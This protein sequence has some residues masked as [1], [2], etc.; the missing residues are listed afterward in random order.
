MQCG[1]WFIWKIAKQTEK[2][3]RNTYPQRKTHCVCV[4]C[5]CEEG[6]EE[7]KEE[8][9]EGKTKNTRVSE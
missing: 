5:V 2:R 3:Q 4:L 8:G 6:R 1:I 9:T 7:W